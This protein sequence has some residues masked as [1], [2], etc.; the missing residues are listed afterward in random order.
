MRKPQAAASGSKRTR[1]CAQKAGLGG[2]SS[3]MAIGPFVEERERTLTSAGS[4]SSWIVGQTLGHKRAV[5]KQ[6]N[7]KGVIQIAQPF[8]CYGCCMM[9][10]RVVAPHGCTEHKVGA[11]R[12]TWQ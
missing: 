5:A 9:S 1:C 10:A 6:E 3:S 8:G 4:W 2:P 11:P 12:K 7:I